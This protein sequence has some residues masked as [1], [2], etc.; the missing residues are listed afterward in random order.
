MISRLCLALAVAAVGTTATTE[1][2]QSAKDLEWEAK[3]Q[4]GRVAVLCGR[5][6]S[7]GCDSKTH[8]TLLYLNDRS[9][10]VRVKISPEQRSTFEGRVEHQYLFRNICVTGTVE[11]R[12]GDY[13]IALSE[14]E[15]LKI[16]D[17]DGKRTDSFGA[18]AHSACEDGIESP[19]L[20]RSAKPQY[21]QAALSAGIE[22]AILLEAVVRED[23]QIGDVRV[24]HSVDQKFGLDEE[25]I[26]ALR[27]WRF[28]PA[29]KFGQP[30][31]ILI[32]VNMSWLL[33][34]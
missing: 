9:S 15:A 20:V 16:Q 29:T 22:G 30:V 12:Q 6:L 21:T 31:P 32:T 1:Q 24:L 23:G 25:A 26:R 17:G 13:D 11:K 14:L 28:K 7:Y 33:R 4:V 3:R 8:S 34:Q 19:K 10:K 27:T 5:V 2:S 18:D